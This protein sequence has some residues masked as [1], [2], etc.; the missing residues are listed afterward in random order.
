MFLYLDCIGILL[1]PLGFLIDSFNYKQLTLDY[2]IVLSCNT[3]TVQSNETDGFLFP[4]DN[5]KGWS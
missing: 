2:N 5:G 3:K 4:S 1:Y